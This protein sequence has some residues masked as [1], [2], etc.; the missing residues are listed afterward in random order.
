MRKC[1]MER[2]RVPGVLRETTIASRTNP[3]IPRTSHL[4]WRLGVENET[5]GMNSGPL[6]RSGELR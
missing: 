1:V 2:P 5:M 4:A 6:R 3:I